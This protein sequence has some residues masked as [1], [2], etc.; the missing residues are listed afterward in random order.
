METAEETLKELRQTYT[1]LYSEVMDQL[2]SL[3]QQREQVQQQLSKWVSCSKFFHLFISLLK[4]VNT[5]QV[6]VSVMF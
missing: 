1:Q 4:T 5:K 2:T 3:T 6:G